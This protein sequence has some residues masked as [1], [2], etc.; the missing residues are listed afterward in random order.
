M[1]FKNWFVKALCG[2]GTCLNYRAIDPIACLIVNVI[3]VLKKVF[4]IGLKIRI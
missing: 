1:S 4:I 2:L 3:Q